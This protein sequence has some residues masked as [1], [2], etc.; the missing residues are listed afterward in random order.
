LLAGATAEHKEAGP[1]AAI[2]ILSETWKNER[3]KKDS[4]VKAHGTKE[5]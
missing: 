2:V 1:E 4:V 5:V 3:S